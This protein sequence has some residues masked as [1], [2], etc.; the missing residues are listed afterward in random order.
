MMFLV[1]IIS[2]GY[3]FIVLGLVLE[4]L[5]YKARPYRTS[6]PSV[7]R[8]FSFSIIINYRNEA[9]NLP[10][11]LHSISGLEYDFDKT[12][13]ILIND[14]SNDN[15][16]EIVQKFKIQNKE[17]PFL[18]IQRIPVSKSAKK[19][20]ITQALEL[21]VHDHIIC[22]DAD[23]I[24]PKKWLQA[25]NK[26][27]QLLPDQHFVAGPVEINISNNISS[28][29]QHSEMVALQMT[30]MGGYAIKQPFMCNGANMSFTKQVFYEVDGYTGNDHISSGDDI[31]L[32]EKLVAEDVLKCSYLKSRDAIVN[33]YPKNGWSSMIK[34]RVRW[35]QKGTATKSGLNKLV[36]FQV[37]VMSLLFV[38]AP[39]LWYF[40]IITTQ[41]L[42][43]VM[44]IK[45][46]VDVIVLFVGNRF[47]NNNKWHLYIIPQ[48]IIYPFLVIAIAFK[49]MEKPSWKERTVNG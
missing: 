46:L 4:G 19:D 23:V 5:T 6:L 13:F 1:L 10:A 27:Y 20:G 41:Q 26:H 9:H 45:V 33:T 16:L 35:A 14:S 25:Y 43:T 29:L 12:Q 38:A 15:G 37:L 21:A 42:V 8:D 28:Q 34:Q 31:F 48:L 40:K 39:A 17:I 47:F 22:T 24:L 18:L 11:L 3:L 2:L 36:S 44:I 7:T 49:S 32:L 30:T